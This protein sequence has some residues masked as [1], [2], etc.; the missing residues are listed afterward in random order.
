MKH[1]L[2]FIKAIIILLKTKSIKRAFIFSKL[3]G[4]SSFFML[5]KYSLLGNELQHNEN[6]NK[7]NIN[8][9]SCFNNDLMML[10]IAF[11]NYFLNEKS[12]KLYMSFIKNEIKITFEINSFDS[13]GVFKEVI[14]QDIYETIL[15]ENILVIDVGM[16]VGISALSFSSNKYVKKVF[17][18][19]PI[20]DTCLIAENNFKLNK[21]LSHKI[22]FICAAL[23]KGD[24]KVQISKPTGGSVGASIT[25]F[26]ISKSQ[27]KSHDSPLIEI[28][29]KDAYTEISKIIE[30][31]KE[32]V[33]LKLDCEGAEFEIIED[34][35]DKNLLNKIFIVIIEW[36]YKDKE[37]ITRRLNESGFVMFAPNIEAEIPAGLIY[38]IN[39][40]N[41]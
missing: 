9:I 41:S 24:K 35:Y 36:H 21:N 30:N 2:T 33:L 11:E 20:P 22:N 27:I 1:I 16:N 34:L 8:H 10:T 14:G 38:G 39:L 6:G 29:V 25:D 40:G 23:A 7:I 13:F 4:G 12:D 18:F 3:K 37:I 28:I 31:N 5:N 17:G 32:K 19:E 26:V 15:N